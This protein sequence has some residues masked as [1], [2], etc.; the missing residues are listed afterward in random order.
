MSEWLKIER[1]K[2]AVFRLQRV[3]R[4]Y[5]ARKGYDRMKREQE[6]RREEERKEQERRREDRREDGTKDNQDVNCNRS[7]PRL[8]DVQ[9]GNVL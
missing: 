7:T 4:G 5:L 3:I 6:R 1:R 8:A 9:V 2:V